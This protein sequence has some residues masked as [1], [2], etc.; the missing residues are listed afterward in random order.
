MFDY[1]D[2]IIISSLFPFLKAEWHLT[3]TQCGSLVSVVYASIVLFTFPIS[4][5]I[6]R[7][8]RRKTVGLMAILWSIAT[9]LGAFTGTFRQLFTT[10]SLIGVGE[11]GYAPGGSA[12][13]SAIYPQEKRS[14]MMGLWNASIP[15]G[16]AIGVAVGGIIATH[17]GWRHALGLVA[18]PGF[19]V[20]VL[21]FFVKD[22][23]TVGLIKNQSKVDKTAERKVVKMSIRGY[24]QGIY[25]KTLPD[26]YLFWH[27][28]G[29]LYHHS[30]DDMAAHVFYPCPGNGSRTGRDEIERGYA[31]GFDGGSP[32]R[33]YCGP[34]AEKK[35][36]C[37]DD[38]SGYLPP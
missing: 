8:S 27:G 30:P 17:F 1:V 35:N 7:W 5:L 4:I 34:V 23:K 22:Y 10:R 19:I 16:S 36:Q 3:D 24:V 29:D 18:I 12:M 26:L 28:R 31:A 33:L 25:A 13:I 38:L 11:A 20:A 21:F 9:G 15:L 6:D 32:W 14:W 2:R 37:P